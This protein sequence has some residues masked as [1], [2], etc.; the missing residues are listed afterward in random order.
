MLP[1]ARSTTIVSPIAREAARMIEAT[2]PERAAGKTT[3]VA[4]FAL[5]API[6]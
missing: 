5:V 3:F 2:M 6:A 1:T 4:T